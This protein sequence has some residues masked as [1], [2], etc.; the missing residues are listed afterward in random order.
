MKAKCGNCGA[1]YVLKD[2]EIAQHT[3]VQFRCTKCGKTSIVNVKLKPDA[4]IVMSPLPSFARTGADFGGS[5]IGMPDAELAMPEGVTASVS[6]IDGPDKG[7][8][9][10]IEKATVI[11]GRQG[12]DVSL[13]DPEVSRSHCLL[14]VKETYVNL[15]DMDST[16]GT[17][18]D[19]E[20]VRAAMLQDGG[21]FRIGSSVIRVNFGRKA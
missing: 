6:V 1:E 9:R 3:K 16:N 10:K 17:F 4:T 19:D 8:V 18:F 13:N 14:E 21:E 20:R 11:L 15:K 12:A 2:A 5:G 7:L